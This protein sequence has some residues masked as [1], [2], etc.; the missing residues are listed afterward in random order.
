MVFPDE[1]TKIKMIK[2]YIIEL[3]DRGIQTMGFVEMK[4]LA[5]NL[6]K[7]LEVTYESEKKV[8][9]K[10]TCIFIAN[11]TFER[12]FDQHVSVIPFHVFIL[13]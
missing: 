9:D 7:A 13:P 8:K 5:Y 11:D 2:S 6:C 10:L 12:D 3:G 4:E 1:K